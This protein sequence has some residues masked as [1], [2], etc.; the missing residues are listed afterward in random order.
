MKKCGFKNWGFCP[1]SREN[2]L[3]IFLAKK[4]PAGFFSG[5]HP[6]KSRLSEQQF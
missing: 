6:S 1:H 4:N 2:C 3:A 5:F